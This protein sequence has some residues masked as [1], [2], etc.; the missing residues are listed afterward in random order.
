MN[1]TVLVFNSM[2]LNVLLLN[3][4][5]FDLIFIENPW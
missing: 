2:M 1:S 3:D 4:L 5:L